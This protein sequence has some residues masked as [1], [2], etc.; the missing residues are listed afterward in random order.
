MSGCSLSAALIAQLPGAIV[1]RRK[2]A[3]WHSATFSGMRLEIDLQIEGSSA[4]GE[5]RLF[6]TYCQDC[7]LPLA[8]LLVADIAVV[9]IR[10][11]PDGAAMTVEALLVE[12]EA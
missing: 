7:Q 11:L 2:D 8:G 4:L 12:D 3:P 6:A 5:V 1:T 9:D 10:E